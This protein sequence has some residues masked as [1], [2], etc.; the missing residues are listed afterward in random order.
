[1]GEFYRQ[2]P[3]A[4]RRRGS[5]QRGDGNKDYIKRVIGMPGDRSTVVNGAFAHKR[6]AGEKR[7]H[8]NGR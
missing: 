2:A 1:M 5:L 3:E 6:R 8:R 7:I 4:R